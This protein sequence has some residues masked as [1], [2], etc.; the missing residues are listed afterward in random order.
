MP[1]FQFLM[2]ALL[3]GMG[4]MTSEV[5]AQ[6]VVRINNV[7][8]ELVPARVGYNQADFLARARIL[9]GT[10]KR[11]TLAVL[12]TPQKQAAVIQAFGNRLNGVYVGA[13]RVTPTG[14]IF[15]Q[16]GKV[17]QSNLWLPGEPNNFKQNEPALE[18]RFAGQRIGFNDISKNHINNGYLVQYP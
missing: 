8:Y 16:N 2:V 7:T 5:Q 18:F 11:G 10:N 12:D 9:P 17:V 13:S 15:W 3:A 6:N 4:L 14:P 1:K